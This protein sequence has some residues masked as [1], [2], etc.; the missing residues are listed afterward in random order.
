M[1]TL[2]EAIEREALHNRQFQELC[3]EVE[4]ILQV[5]RDITGVEVCIKTSHYD[6]YT[7]I[8][9]W[10]WRNREAHTV[11]AVTLNFNRHEGRTK[12]AVWMDGGWRDQDVEHPYVIK[13]AI[14]FLRE[15]G[16]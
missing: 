14:M 5:L 13:E 6:G 11:R 9:L 2:Q 4:P 7:T 1:K 10:C 8:V 16:G 15:W 12:V 3:Q